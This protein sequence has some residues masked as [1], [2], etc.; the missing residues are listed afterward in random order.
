VVAQLK[1]QED[2]CV[3]LRLDTSHLT[4]TAI[5]DY[6][7]KSESTS[8]ATANAP[9]AS[10]HDI[11]A[12]RIVGARACFI[13]CW[14]V[15][16]QCYR[17]QAQD[18]VTYSAPTGYRIES[19]NNLISEATHG[20][21]S[22]VV[23]PNG[24]TLNINAEANGHICY[25]GSEVCV[26]CPDTIQAWAGHARRQVQVNL[27]STTPTKQIGEEEV[28]MITTRGLCCCASGIGRYKF[29]ERVVGIR[30]IPAQ[31]AVSRAAAS[32]AA[33]FVAAGPA[34]MRTALG[35]THAVDGEPCVECADKAHRAAAGSPQAASATGR[36]SEARYTLQQVNELSN[37]IKA[38]TIRSL[39][40]PY[41]VPQKFIETN[42]FAKQLEYK[43]LQTR[44]GRE[45]IRSQD[46]LRLPN[47]AVSRLASYLKKDT[48]SVTL[49]DVLTF[50]NADLAKIVGLDE[51][52]L[53]RMK[54]ASLGIAFK[55]SNTGEKD[56]GSSRTKRE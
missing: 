18:T 20:S 31:L 32:Y 46:A 51:A 11:P 50:R 27:V 47:E 21:T 19:Y 44:Q 33:S 2:F 28:L 39:N 7:R 6:D 45:I 53:Q 16:Y 26:D 17:T 42:F 10:D 1:E 14:D 3:S 43:V 25:E 55:N 56:G 12:E 38:E 34:P 36:V 24:Q 5:M 35:H 48:N 37:F 49:E 4:K 9:V 8:I 54:L 22:V 29:N 40:D 13:D 52:E 30:A 23:T 15:H 41:V